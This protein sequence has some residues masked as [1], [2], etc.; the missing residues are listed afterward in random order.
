MK[1]KLAKMASDKKYKEFTKVKGG[2]Y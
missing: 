2:A 1:S